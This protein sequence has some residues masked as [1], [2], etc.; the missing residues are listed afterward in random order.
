MSS[1]NSGKVPQAVGNS[2]DK[3]IFGLLVLI[4]IPIGVAVA[5]YCNYIKCWSVSAGARGQEDISKQVIESEPPE[6]AFV[7]EPSVQASAS[8][9]PEQVFGSEAEEKN[10]V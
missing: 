5:F 4:L 1:L 8:L 10:I 3:E 7:S 6:Q 2:T 9:P